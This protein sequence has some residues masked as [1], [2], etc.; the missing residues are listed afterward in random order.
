MGGRKMIGRKIRVELVFG[1]AA[2][3]LEMPSS[4]VRSGILAHGALQKN[5]A[6][7]KTW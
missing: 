5:H 3:G 2:D 6:D 4:S 1:A 7:P